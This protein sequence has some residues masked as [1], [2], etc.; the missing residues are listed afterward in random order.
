ML[1]ALQTALV[2]LP[3]SRRYLVGVSGGRDS[4]CL[5]HA[6]VDLGYRNLIVCHLN[7]CLRG[8]ESEADADFVQRLAERLNCTLARADIDVAEYAQEHSLSLETAGRVLRQQW[9][10]ECAKEFRTSMIFLAHHAD[11]QAETVLHHLLRGTGL[12]GLGGMR[13]EIELN[14]GLHIL[15]P[16]LHIRRAELE[17]WASEKKIRWR[18]DASNQ[19]LVYT[20]NRLRLQALPMLNEIMERDVVPLLH[21]LSIVARMDDD[22]LSELTEQ[23]MHRVLAPDGS[24]LA[25]SILAQEHTAI[26][27]RVVQAWLQRC[28]VPSLTQGHISAVVELLKGKAPSRSNL[29]GGWQVRRKSKT[30]HLTRQDA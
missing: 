12:A 6:L 3:V 22:C 2:H 5:L 20:R 13:P 25:G 15:R 10:A 17:Q 23:V 26:Q 14:N 27:Y 30:L 16:M 9:F 19:E 7:H 4:V 24:A 11:D 8:A 29:P 18:E 1:A 28:S 21:R